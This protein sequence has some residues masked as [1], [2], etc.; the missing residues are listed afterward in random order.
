VTHVKNFFEVSSDTYVEVGLSGATGHNDPDEQYRTYTGGIDLTLK[1]APVGRSK[2]RTLEWRT[3]YLYGYYEQVHTD[4]RSRGFYSSLRNKM[5]ARIW[6][7]G[8]VGYA[9]FPYDPDQYEW[10]AVVHLD[11][12]QSDFV[13]VRFQYNYTDRHYTDS[14]LYP[15]DHS[16]LFHIC[17]SM[18]P[19][20]HEAY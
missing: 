19:H 11:F 15:D 18:G 8:R 13:F 7:G 20:K 9:E 6:I 16:F 1:W 10:D 12:W 2:Y 17:W 4:L 5:N 3:E 14:N